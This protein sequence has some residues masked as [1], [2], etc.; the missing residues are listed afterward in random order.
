MKIAFNNKLILNALSAKFLGL[1][2]DGTLS[3]RMHIDH[4]T[5]K[6]GSTCYVIRSIKPLKSHKTLQVIYHSLSHTGM[7]YG[8]IF[9]GNSYH[10]IQFECK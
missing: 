6:L 8:K 4:L 10:S 9:W 3:W 7:S 5:T 1:T 2:V